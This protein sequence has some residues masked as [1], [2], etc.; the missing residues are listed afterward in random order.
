MAKENK[1]APKR[2]PAENLKLKNK[3]YLEQ[4]RRLHVELVKLQEWVKAKGTRF[5]LSSR[6]AMVPV[7]AG[8]SKRSPNESARVS[9]GWWRYMRLLIERKARCMSSAIC[10]TCPQRVKW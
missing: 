6:G 4:L 8:R 1:K 9:F 5:A 2:N 10:R 3:D 7:R